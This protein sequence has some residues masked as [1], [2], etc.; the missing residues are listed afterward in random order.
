MLGVMDIKERRIEKPKD[1]EKERRS[2]SAKQKCNSLKNMSVM[3]YTGRFI[4]VRVGFGSNDRGF[5]TSS[6][7]HLRAG[8][9]FSAAEC[10]ATDGGFGGDGPVRFSHKNPNTE[11]KI[12]FNVMFVKWFPLLGA[13]KSKLPYDHRTVK[14][15]IHAAARLHNWLMNT[16][17]LDY[18]AAQNPSNYFRKYY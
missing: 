3:D 10:I 5:F 17:N 15:A 14:L 9:F 2:F 13:N 8:E 11:D 12:L 16:E 18:D 1:R 6:D 7:L 4:Y